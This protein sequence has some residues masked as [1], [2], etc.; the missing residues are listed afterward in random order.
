MP[1]IEHYKDL[2]DKVYCEDSFT[3]LRNLE[4]PS[5]DLT[6]TSPPYY[7]ARD[8]SVYES[9]GDY[10]DI[11]TDI[12][13]EV[14]RTTKDGRFLVVNTSPVIVPRKN[15]QDQSRRLPI[16]FDLNTRLVDM[17][18]M[19][20]E[21][22]VWLKPEPSVKNRV[23]SFDQHRKPL[24]YKP[25]CVTEFLMVYRKKTDKLI[26]SIYKQYSKEALEESKIEDGYESTNVWAISPVR[27]K[28]HSAVFPISLCDK[29][30]KYYSFKNDLVLDPFAGSGSVGISALQNNRHF[31]LIEKNKQYFKNITKK[32]YK[33][34]NTQL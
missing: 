33:W 17:G 22:I 13:K 24:A 28:D 31:T 10:L 11:M 9:Y 30:I 27:D 32:L 19:F 25:N 26:D 8:Y 12:F 16:P 34:K 1:H 18:W 14:H 4:Y 21:D 15:R 7:N 2:V 6:F 5:F 20:M 3:L 23:A 29:V